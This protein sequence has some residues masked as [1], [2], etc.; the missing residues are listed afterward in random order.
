MAAAPAQR[1]RS[2]RQQVSIR[3]V[4]QRVHLPA[5]PQHFSRQLLR[6]A[7]WLGMGDEH[8]IGRGCHEAIAGQAVSAVMRRSI[9]LTRSP[10]NC[11]SLAAPR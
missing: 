8:G 1:L 2:Q 11:S 7:A 10:P 4:I 9:S 3:R 6:L 5:P